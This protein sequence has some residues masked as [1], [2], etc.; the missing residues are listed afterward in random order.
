MPTQASNSPS[1]LPY[2]PHSSRNRGGDASAA[3]SAALQAPE[4]N[5]PLANPANPRNRRRE[6]AAQVGLRA[7]Q[8]DLI[9]LPHLA[10]R[11]PA[12]RTAELPCSFSLVSGPFSGEYRS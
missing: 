6:S 4:S 12:Y 7:R 11:L 9:L 5:E 10:G 3:S 2:F 8:S 1:L